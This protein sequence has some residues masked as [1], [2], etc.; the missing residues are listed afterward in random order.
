MVTRMDVSVVLPALNEEKSIGKT[1]K[2]LKKILSYI[3]LECEI[4]V[5]D[6][7]SEDKTADIVRKHGAKVINERQRGYGN[8]LR[9]G[10]RESQGTYVI[11]YDPDGSYDINTIPRM[12]YLLDD[13]YDYVNANRFA[14]L[15][16]N[17]MTFKNFVGNKIINFVGSLF[18][19]VSGKDMLSGFKAFKKEALEKM[20]LKAQKWDINVEMHSKI[21]KNGLKFAEV[22]TK[23][24]PRIGAS[25]LSGTTAAWNNFRYMLMYSP[26]F[27]F[28]YPSIFLMILS[29]LS[30]LIILRSSSLGNVSLLLFAMIFMIGFQMLLFG[31][32]SKT[33]L[34]RKGFENLSL[35]SRLGSRLT[36]EK[37]ITASLAIFLT[38]FII[39][40]MLL[41][42]WFRSGRVLELIDI[43]LGIVGFTLMMSS[44]SILTYSFI[45]QTLSE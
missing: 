24:Y 34:Y 22:A 15:T 29:I 9:R 13:G 30:A 39:F 36:I 23:Y 12:I 4:I 6:S 25:K 1:L 18:F 7:D 16:N 8:A 45:N 10:F 32:M 43:K 19:G 5:V 20:D 11:M 35:L 44:I 26:N 21:R 42:K 41:I 37:G 33:Y 31:I 38:S 40:L 17:S 2:E 27:I 3:K 28:V 14:R